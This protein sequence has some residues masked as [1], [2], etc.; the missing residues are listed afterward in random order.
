[1]FNIN[2]EKYIHDG[3]ADYEKIISIIPIIIMNMYGMEASIPV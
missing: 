2:G 3:G 1:M